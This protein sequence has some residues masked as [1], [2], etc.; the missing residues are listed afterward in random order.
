MKRYGSINGDLREQN[1]KSV[2]YYAIFFPVVELIGAISLAL[3][4]WY[5]GGQVVRQALSFGTLFAFIQYVDMFYR[6][7]RDL[8]EKY[9]V[10]QAA[11]AASERVFKVLDTKPEIAISESPK[12]LNG[13]SGSIEFDKINFAYNPDQYV[14][15]D[16]HFKIKPG[17]KVALV[18]AT[19]AGKTSTVSLLCRFYD[20]NSGAIKFDGVDIR[21]LDPN[22]LR[23]QLGLVLQ[24]VF[25]FS[26]TIKENITLGAEDISDEKVQIA[27][28]QVGLT[29]F[30]NRLENRFE[31]MVGERG[32]SLS[33]GQRQLISFARALA[34][35]PKVL[36]L[37][38]ATSS[39]DNETEQI[40]QSAIKKMFE[41]R[42]SVIVAHRLSTIKE[43]DKILVFHKG[44]IVEQG[45]H[46]ELLK[47][48]GIYWRLY[49]LQYQDQEVV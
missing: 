43:A 44:R 21:N 20:I 14:L 33:V 23:S 42:T 48:R 40:I 4:V 45:R 11:M 24:D 19:G 34:R 46:E 7:M 9:N 16:V 26:G 38:E 2:L 18:G 36:I 47:E 29:P 25:L 22:E 1:Q 6:P 17:E 37:D 10:L 13:F 5:G 41:G 15:R 32:T 31:H 3:I 39:V 28:N 8:A 12:S 30:I 49:Q 27:A 35:D